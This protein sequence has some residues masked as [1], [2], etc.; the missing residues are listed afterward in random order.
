MEKKKWVGW[1]LAAV[2]VVVA[3]VAVAM[4]NQS[5]DMPMENVVMEEE[6]AIRH[7]F[8]EAD[9]GEAGVANMNDAG[10]QGSEFVYV[11]NKG[12]K[13]VGYAVKE[14]VKGYAG[15]IDVISGMET[16]G[17]LRG[18]YVGGKEFAE[19]EGY[20]SKAKDAAFTD[21]FA[22]KSLPVELGNNIDAIS[23]ATVT[24]RA[25]VDGVNSGMSKIDAIIGGSSATEMPTEHQRIANASVI[26]YAGP[27]LVR[28][29]L[30]MEGVITSLAIGGERFMETEGIGSKVKD[31]EFISQFI[32][33]KPPFEM[34]DIDAIAGATVSTQAALE[35]VNE[36]AAFITQE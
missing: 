34:T 24:S 32:G 14:S 4:T 10:A 19:T 33:K 27:V 8:P 6:A 22:G 35:A 18:V 15:M 30:D 26:G 5:E 17:V 31:E 11:V 36:A 7:L 20:G 23:G 9:A 28:V 12:G 13:P 25:V 16:S 1:L 29:G 21:Q 3:A 2:I